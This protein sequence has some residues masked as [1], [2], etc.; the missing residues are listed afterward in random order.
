MT[1]HRLSTGVEGL[2][3]VLCGGLIG[4]RTYL[5]TGPPGSGKTTLGWHFLVDGV[6][7]GEPVLYISF[8]EPE[9][10]LRDNAERSGFDPRT[11]DVLDLSPAAE[12]FAQ[13]ESYDIFSAREVES[14]PTT[15]R[16][17]ET[18][19]RV[20][21]RR[22]FVD[23]MTHLRHLAS[24]AYQFRRQ[25]LAFLRFLSAHDTTV[26]ITSESTPGA[27]DDDL[28][29]IVDGV[30]ELGFVNRGRDIA[31]LKY[32]GSDC[33]HGRHALALG[34]EGVN[35]FPRLVPESFARPFLAAQLGSGLPD[36]DEL[37]GGG[38]ERGTVTLISGPTGVGKTTLGVQVLTEAANRGDRCALYTF[39]ER[40][41][42]VVSRCEGVGMGVRR[43]IAEGTLSI[44]ELEALKFGPDEFAAIVRRDIEERGTQVVMIDS[45]S[46]Y[47][48]SV[49]GD[50]AERLHAL[51]RYLQNIG[52]T[53]IL[54]DELR[55]VV[56][57]HVTDVGISYLADNILF[58]RYVERV[59]GEAIELRKGIGVLKKRLS[60]FQKTL[61]EFEVAHDG[62]RIGEALRLS[63][64]LNQLPADER[65]P[66]NA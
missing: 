36:L 27:P 46:G 64:I 55:D 11:V 31:V 7:A 60:D 10:E 61:R 20:K 1:D 45:V 14:E 51:A 21:P 43:L 23:S 4:G 18:M 58:L 48:V 50:L 15:A 16:I 8:A 56:S 6:A 62:I 30:I 3:E 24:D 47:R 42:T 35:V 53:V 41:E 49:S 2:D 37:L 33:R 5:L 17:V 66:T 40:A 22:V 12:L 9:A 19:A 44:V 34:A 13:S 25:A 59:I 28:R 52:V 38:I 54:V 65:T 26:M 63:S 39:D 29:F 32:R 57:F